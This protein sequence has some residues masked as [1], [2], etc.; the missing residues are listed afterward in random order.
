MTQGEWKLQS[1]KVLKYNLTDEQTFSS[2]L[3]YMVSD[4]SEGRFPPCPLGLSDFIDIA[5]YIDILFP[6]K[7]SIFQPRVSIFF[8]LLFF[9][10]NFIEKSDVTISGNTEH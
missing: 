8:L 9:L 4:Y 3:V 2:N 6:D 1:M 7:V 10:A 5:I